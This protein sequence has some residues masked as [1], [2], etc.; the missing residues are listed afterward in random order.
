[1]NRSA[2]LSSTLA[3]LAGVAFA[4]LFFFSLAVVD[5]QRDVTDQQ[6]LT[7]WSDAAKQRDT[8]VSMYAMLLSAPF[9][10]VFLVELRNRLRSA[11]PN[12]ESWSGLV[13]GAGI[14]FV[15]LLAV[16]AFSRGVIAQSIRFSDDPIPGPDT[17]RYATALSQAAFGIAAIPFVAIAVTTASVIILRTGALARWL[18]WLGIV[19]AA[20]SLV[21]IVALVGAL[22]SPLVLIWVVAA[23]FLIWR[24]RNAVAGAEV[25]RQP[26]GG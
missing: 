1:M 24:T 20:A 23:S 19:V 8:I 11:G 17:L 14:A 21:A 18:G 5:P 10:L 7:W 2:P 22:A 4:L 16:T 6:L 3:A 15:A 26:T 12:A 13:F 25:D 9:F